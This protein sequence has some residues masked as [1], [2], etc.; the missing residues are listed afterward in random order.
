MRL[1]I[2]GDTTPAAFHIVNI[3]NRSRP[4]QCQTGAPSTFHTSVR[5]Q[6]IGHLYARREG[7]IFFLLYTENAVKICT[8]VTIINDTTTIGL[9]PPARLINRLHAKDYFYIRI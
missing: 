1:T 4:R 3:V 6:H 2:T 8:H 5:D 9:N 7:C